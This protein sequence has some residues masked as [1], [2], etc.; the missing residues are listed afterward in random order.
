MGLG[1]RLLIFPFVLFAAAIWAVLGLFFWI[2]LLAKSV[3]I[4]TITLLTHAIVD[5]P[6]TRSIDNFQRAILYYLH[7]FFI[8][9][10]T[11]SRPVI[12]PASDA[13]TDGSDT[14]LVASLFSN[15]LGLI[16]MIL[17]S[18]I[19]WL[20]LIFLVVHLNL[21]SSPELD[22]LWLRILAILQSWGF[23]IPDEP[24]SSASTERATWWKEP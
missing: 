3:T 20:S 16:G 18:S 1:G 17:F 11:L 13:H 8:I 6:M 21:V 14:G 19:F 4:F 9:I 7:G 22:R 2:P 12:H 10:S 23:P 24:M 15:I 5:R